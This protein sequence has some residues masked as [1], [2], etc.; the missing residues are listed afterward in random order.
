[1]PTRLGSG[2][3]KANFAEQLQALYAMHGMPTQQREAIA[4][5]LETFVD[6]VSPQ[7]EVTYFEA[8]DQIMIGGM[9]W[10]LIDAP[11]HASGQL[12]FYQQERKWMLCGDQ[13]LPHITP[14]VSIV[15][16]E[17]GDPLEAFLDSLQELASYEVQ[18]CFSW[19]S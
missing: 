11:G 10:L 15:P 5:N 14:N 4:E 17:D 7:P 18:A 9:S 2:E 13:V 1:M 3:R 8:G 19:T 6:M 12:C 16:G